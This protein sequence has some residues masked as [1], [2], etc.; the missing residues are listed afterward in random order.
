MATLTCVPA[1]TILPAYVPLRGEIP[2]SETAGSDI[3]NSL[4]KRPIA[5]YKNLEGCL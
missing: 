3:R 5:V 4:E 2:K 1:K